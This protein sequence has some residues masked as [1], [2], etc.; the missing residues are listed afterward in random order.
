MR[1]Y[2]NSV[3]VEEL[4][5]DGSPYKLWD[6]DQYVCD[7]CGTTIISGFAKL[8]LVEH[9]QPD[10]QEIRKRMEPIF[11]GRSRP[12]KEEAIIPDLV[13]G[14]TSAE[15]VLCP[16]GCKKQ[17]PAGTTIEGAHPE[18]YRHDERA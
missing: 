10:Y 3:T 16:C 18:D 6:A 9:Y 4:M 8:P 2:R 5:D 1:C 15:M 12:R 11:P 17:V 7:D 13:G 14:F